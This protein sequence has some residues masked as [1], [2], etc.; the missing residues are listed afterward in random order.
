MKQLAPRALHPPTRVWGG[1]G[2]CAWAATNTCTGAAM[3]VTAR[4]TS[5]GLG[6][7]RSPP[8]PPPGGCRSSAQP[9]GRDSRGH[10]Q[11]E[12]LHDV[13][14]V[15]RAAVREEAGGKDDDG[16]EAFAVVAWGDAARV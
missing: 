3:A 15:G 14:V 1:L 7:K 10:S 5:R 8:P 13:V 16:V 12:V 4:R 6:A 2:E 11:E 9:A